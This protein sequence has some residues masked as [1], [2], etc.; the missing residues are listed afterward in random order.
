MPASDKVAVITTTPSKRTLPA[1]KRHREPNSA[2]V[3]PSTGDASEAC[4]YGVRSRV[5]VPAWA[6]VAD[7]SAWHRSRHSPLPDSTRHRS[8]AALDPA[9]LLGAAKGGVYTRILATQAA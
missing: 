1:L 5:A 8:A 6:L 4:R 3:A 9:T 2:V 7:S